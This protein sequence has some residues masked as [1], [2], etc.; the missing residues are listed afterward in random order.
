[1]VEYLQCGA[2][3]SFVFGMNR[4]LNLPGDTDSS[5]LV[6]SMSHATKQADITLIAVRQLH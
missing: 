6:N 1:M 3:N 5:M 4:E 2:F